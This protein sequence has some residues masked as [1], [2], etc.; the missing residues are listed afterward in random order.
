[1]LD[2]LALL[3]WIS[4]I[5]LPPSLPATAPSTATT[6]IADRLLLTL[7]PPV[8]TAGR[9]VRTIVRV[10]RNTANRRLRVEV[11]GPLYGASTERQLDGEQAERTFEML[12]QSLPAGEYTV[13]VVVEGTKGVRHRQE[14]VLTVV[15]MTDDPIGA[16]PRAGRGRR[17]SDP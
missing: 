16:P 7:S 6:R 17:A 8:T 5:G 4:L 1:M 10:D 9:N 2:A 14:R 13:I 3:G 11:D 15:G 12:W